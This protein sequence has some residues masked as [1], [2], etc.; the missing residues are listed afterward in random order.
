MKFCQKCKSMMLPLNGVFKCKKCGHTSIIK[1]TDNISF[2]TEIRDKEVTILEGE[3]NEGLP[4]TEVLCIEC[5]NKIAYWWLRQLRSADE[6]ET[7][8]F[9]C[10]KCSYTWREYN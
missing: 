6:S 3:I 7:R 1:K 9:K 10:T 4:T 2:K 8:F 5:K